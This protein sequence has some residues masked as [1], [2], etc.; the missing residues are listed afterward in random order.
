MAVDVRFVLVRIL[1]SWLDRRFALKLKRFVNCSA[2]VSST[3]DDSLSIERIS[4]GDDRG[5]ASTVSLTFD[6]VSKPSSSVS[7]SDRTNG[8]VGNVWFLSWDVFVG[9]DELDVGWLSSS[10]CCTDEGDVK[11]LKEEGKK[12]RQLQC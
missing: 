6:W 7:E 10:T 12:A 4:I 8:T 5:I 3:R 11:S 2:N 1:P 9:K